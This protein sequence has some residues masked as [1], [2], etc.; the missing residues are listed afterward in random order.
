MTLFKFSFTLAL[1]NAK[2]RFFKII[3]QCKQ[4]A[5]NGHYETLVGKKAD[6][7]V[8]GVSVARAVRALALERTTF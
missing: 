8:F 7:A 4:E 2:I 3:D 5:K 1:K 6:S